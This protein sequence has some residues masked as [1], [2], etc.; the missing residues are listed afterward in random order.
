MLQVMLSGKI[1]GVCM[2]FALLLSAGGVR[3][4]LN[5]VACRSC[6]MQGAHLERFN[7]ITLD[8]S[9]LSTNFSNNAVDAIAAFTKLVNDSAQMAGLPPSFL[10]QAA[11]KVRAPF[12]LRAS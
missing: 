7:S 11:Q 10:A 4:L 9:T 3:F 6:P 2:M 12:P 5:P 8:L 1:G